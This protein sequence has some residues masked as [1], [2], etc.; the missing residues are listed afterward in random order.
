MM[1][2]AAIIS[3]SLLH[4]F[5]IFLYVS[6]IEMHPLVRKITADNMKYVYSIGTWLKSS[7]GFRMALT[8]YI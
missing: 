3:V 7:E 2:I 1:V 6:I 4:Y 5:K 8:V